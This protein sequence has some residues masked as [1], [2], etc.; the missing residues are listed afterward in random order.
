MKVVGKVIKTDKKTA[1]VTVK[2]SS[3]CVS[4]SECR[5]KNVCHT[6]LMLGKQNQNITLEA[7]NPI[8]AKEADTVEVASSTSKTLS[9]MSLVFVLPIILSVVMYFTF[10]RI[11]ISDNY[12]TVFMAVVF[13]TVFLLIALFMNRYVK[14]H[15]TLEIIKIIEESKK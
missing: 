15:I 14:K 6:H 13:I 1:T 10:K 9:A 11:G 3:A 12:A 8:G 2:R 5:Q 7:Y 4:C